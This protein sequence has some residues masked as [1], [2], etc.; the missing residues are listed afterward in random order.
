MAVVM[1]IVVFWDVVLFSVV[2]VCKISEVPTVPS[3]GIILQIEAIWSFETS[4]NFY[5]PTQRYIP[6]RTVVSILYGGLKKM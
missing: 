1:K 2:K 6:Y 5:R 4:I 3:L